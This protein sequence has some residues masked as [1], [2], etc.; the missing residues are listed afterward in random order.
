MTEEVEP[1]EKQREFI[2]NVEGFYLV[3]AGA[4]TGKTLAITH[5]YAHLL[6]EEG[7]DPQDIL[8]ITFTRNAA[9]NMKERIIGR[10]ST[11]SVRLHDAPIS[12][13][14]AYCKKL[15]TEHGFESP[16]FLGIDERISSSFKIVENK[17]RERQEFGRF[18]GGFKERYPEYQRFYRLVSDE[19]ELLGM[20]KSLASKGIFPEKGGWY[21]NSESHLR[22]DFE[23]F[24]DRFGEMN[25]PEEGKRG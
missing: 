8:L 19:E 24:M 6:D 10:C 1:N 3:D 18:Y 25:V 22:G 2:Q 13:F 9:E 21:R 11:E 17:V 7:V 20:I 16:K 23:E 5:R 15:V 12:T 4:G 14:H